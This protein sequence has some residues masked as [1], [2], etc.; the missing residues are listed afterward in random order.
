MYK[1]SLYKTLKSVDPISQSNLRFGKMRDQN[2]VRKIKKG[3][4]RLKIKEKI[5]TKYFRITKNS[6]TIDQI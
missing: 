5:V 4:I 1:K 6:E 2:D 3:S